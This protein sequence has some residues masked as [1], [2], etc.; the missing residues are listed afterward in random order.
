MT[1]SNPKGL[2]PYL[3]RAIQYFGDSTEPR[4]VRP[5][6]LGRFLWPVEAPEKPK[7]DVGISS[8]SPEMRPRH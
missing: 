2:P 1:R 3:L 6:A 8:P 7:L 4:L 5:G